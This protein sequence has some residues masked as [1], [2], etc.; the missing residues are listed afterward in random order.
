[1]ELYELLEAVRDE[2]TFVA[3]AKA[4]LRDL[5]ENEAEWEN[6]TIENFL[7]AGIAWA[8]S[9]QVGASQGLAAASP[10][11]RAASFLYCGKIYE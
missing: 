3:F 7:E 11:K 5:R 8:E 9:T 4:L 1:M 2:T 6:G 10:W